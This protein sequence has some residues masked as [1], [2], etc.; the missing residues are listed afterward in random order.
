MRHIVNSI[1]AA[2]IIIVVVI[3]INI[4]PAPSLR[5]FTY[6]MILPLTSQRKLRVLSMKF[7]N[8]SYHPKCGCCAFTLPSL[9]PSI[10]DK[11]VPF[12]MAYRP[13]HGCAL[14]ATH[15]TQ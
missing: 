12:S 9:P 10:T 8:V 1:F 3:I 2:I 13:P 6:Q 14:L 15:L 4:A 7:L 11:G 5:S